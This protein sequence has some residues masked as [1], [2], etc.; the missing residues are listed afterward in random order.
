MKLETT[1]FPLTLAIFRFHLEKLFCDIVIQLCKRALLLSTHHLRV[2]LDM[3]YYTCVKSYY[4]PDV[5]IGTCG[6]GGVVFRWSLWWEYHGL[7]L[8]SESISMW[9][10]PPGYTHVSRNKYMSTFYLMTFKI[11]QSCSYKINT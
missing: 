3:A 2:W 10:Y 6:G 9:G 11:F 8:F 4:H 7:L 1:C 5:G